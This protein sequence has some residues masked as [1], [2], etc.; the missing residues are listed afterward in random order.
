MYIIL[1]MYIIIIKLKWIRDCNKQLA[2]DIA[3]TYVLPLTQLR[4][5]SI[6]II[7]IIIRKLTLVLLM[8]EVPCH[9]F[10]NGML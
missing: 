6:I 10:T 2:L 1:R 7:V 9:L 8:Y 3:C 4:Y 5:N